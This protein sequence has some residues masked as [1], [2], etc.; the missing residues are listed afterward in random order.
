MH[1][2]LDLLPELLG[3]VRCAVDQAT[4]Q[5]LVVG[6]HVEINFPPIEIVSIY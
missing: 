5:L 6:N 4:E 2:E 1:H 3:P